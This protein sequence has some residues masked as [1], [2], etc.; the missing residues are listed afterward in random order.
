MT[1]EDMLETEEISLVDKAHAEWAAKGS[2]R[3]PDILVAASKTIYR[4][5]TE[6]DSKN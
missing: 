6:N 1:I 4:M 2:N 3:Y 5:G